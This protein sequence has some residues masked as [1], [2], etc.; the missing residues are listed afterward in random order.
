MLR[1][2]IYPY[3][4]ALQLSA[5]DVVGNIIGKKDKKSVGGDRG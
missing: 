3:S 4:S 5:S 1:P 2:N